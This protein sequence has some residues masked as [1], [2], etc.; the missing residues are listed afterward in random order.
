MNLKLEPF[1]S[2]LLRKR[3]EPVT[4][5]ETQVKPYYKQMNAIMREPRNGISGV[6]L[7]APQV[8]ILWRFF[9]F[10]PHGIP[11]TC[12]NPSIGMHSEE[13]ETGIEGCLSKPGFTV[14]VKRRAWIVADWTDEKGK[15]YGRKL[16]GRVARIF[17]HEIDHLNGINIFP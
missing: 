11:M 6:G 16:E 12:V 9:V 4:D 1:D 17:Q 14:G 3:C 7:A 2:A 10:A 13:L 15:G 8:G 5:I